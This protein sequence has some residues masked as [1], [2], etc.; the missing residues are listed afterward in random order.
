[1]FAKLFY[2]QQKGGKAKKE[3]KKFSFYLKNKGR[4]TEE[5][6]GRNCCVLSKQQV[7]TGF[8]TKREYLPLN[9]NLIKS[10]QAVA[11]VLT[12]HS[13]SLLFFLFLNITALKK[14][15][16]FL[17]LPCAHCMY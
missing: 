15:L 11:I 7:S 16:F 8:H 12:C 14:I 13:G 1:M 6:I 3:A 2:K 5:R 17:E 10:N 9:L 4:I